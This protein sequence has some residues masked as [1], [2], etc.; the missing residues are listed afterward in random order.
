M[1]VA[2]TDDKIGRSDLLPERN[3][4]T[5]TEQCLTICENDLSIDSSEMGVVLRNWID[6]LTSRW[7]TR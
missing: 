6:F 1:P 4:T 7:K 5:D 2:S 3:G